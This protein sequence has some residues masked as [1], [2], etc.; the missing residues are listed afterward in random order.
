[1]GDPSNNYAYA[2]QIFLMAVPRRI[3]LIGLI[4]CPDDLGDLVGGEPSGGVIL[5]TEV[6]GQGVDELVHGQVV[7]EVRAN[8]RHG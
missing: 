1:M 6:R 5:P 2:S 7:R 4:A 3:C 8:V